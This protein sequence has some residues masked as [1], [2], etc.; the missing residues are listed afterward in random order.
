MN[1]QSATASPAI[2]DPAE[3][4]IHQSCKRPTESVVPRY[5]KACPV[6][7]RCYLKTNQGSTAIDDDGIWRWLAE[8]GRKVVLN[9][10]VSLDK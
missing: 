4:I 6:L 8:Q 2:S 3:K 5:R 10:P 9:D 7:E 1:R